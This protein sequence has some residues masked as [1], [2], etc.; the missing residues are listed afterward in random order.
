MGREGRLTAHSRTHNQPSAAFSTRYLIQESQ[1]LET[2]TMCTN[3]T[4]GA[5]GI[6]GSGDRVYDINDRA[7]D[8]AMTIGPVSQGVRWQWM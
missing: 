5:D 7:L 3:L 8:S 2:L 6:F 4:R 1:D